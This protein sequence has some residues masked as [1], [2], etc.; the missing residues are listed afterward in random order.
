MVRHQL[1][2]DDVRKPTLQAAHGFLAG[3]ALAPFALVVGP[4]L[5][6]RVAQLGD[7]HQVDGVVEPA[8]ARAVEAVA[9]LLPRADVDR[10]RAVVGG[11]V[12]LVGEPGDI[13]YLGQ[14]PPGD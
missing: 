5:A 8:V 9:D 12:V 14:H 1:A 4:A 10:R 11:E 3:L 2:V 7:R 6:A 13:A